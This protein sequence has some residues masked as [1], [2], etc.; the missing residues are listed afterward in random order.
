MSRASTCSPSVAPGCVAV[1]MWNSRSQRRGV[2]LEG[3]GSEARPPDPLRR[4]RT[5]L[6]ASPPPQGGFAGCL[7]WLSQRQASAR[8]RARRRPRGPSAP[9]RGD[10][11][12][13]PQRRKR[14]IARDRGDRYC[15]LPETGTLRRAS[16]CRCSRAA[17][18]DRGA[19]HRSSCGGRAPH[20]RAPHAGCCVRSNTPGMPAQPAAGRVDT[21]LV[22]EPSRS[23]A[24][25]DRAR[26]DLRPAPVA[27]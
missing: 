27:E 10:P 6:E 17:A 4:P 20:R 22:R 18:T 2:T 19:R 15:C 21:R 5:L 25:I 24:E 23:Y 1:L 26:H 14:L 7:G 11:R 12:E 9:C 16:G 13:A 8:G 3:G